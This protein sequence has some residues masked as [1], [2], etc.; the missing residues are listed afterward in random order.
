MEHEED[1]LVLDCLIIAMSD[2]ND[3]RNDVL[4]NLE[5]DLYPL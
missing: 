4:E 3:N 5:E 1:V 2:D